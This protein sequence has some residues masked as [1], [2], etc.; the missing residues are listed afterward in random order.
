MF[1]IFFLL[2]NNRGSSSAAAGKSLPTFIVKKSPS[3]QAIAAFI[4]SQ[5][6][7]PTLVSAECFALQLPT[8]H[9]W[10]INDANLGDIPVYFKLQVANRRSMLNW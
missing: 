6:R 7:E 4:L 5:L 2:N 1:F 9:E 8:V 10:L 3:P